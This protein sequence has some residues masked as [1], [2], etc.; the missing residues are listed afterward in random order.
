[1]RTYA[2][3]AAVALLPVGGLLLA[4][5]T[6]TP[7]LAQGAPSASA[8]VVAV[9]VVTVPLASG[10]ASVDVPVDG[11]IVAL[12][13][14]DLGFRIPGRLARVAVKFGERVKRGQVLAELEAN[15][16]ALSAKI[17]VAQAAQARAG[18]EAAEDT[19]GR[20]KQLA[21]EGFGAE[22]TTAGST[23]ALAQSRAAF[24]AAIA[25]AA[26]SRVQVGEHRLLAP[27]DGVVA[28]PPLAV[29]ALVMQTTVLHLIDD[30][31][32]RFRGALAERHALSLAPGAKLPV[33]LVDGTEIEGVVEVLGLR[34]DAI[35]GNVP[36]EV[37]LPTSLPP[38]VRVGA[39]ARGRVAAPVAV[40]RAPVAALRTLGGRDVVL[41]PR[42]EIAVAV[43]V[44]VVARSA[45]EVSFLADLPANA[46]VVVAP[47]ELPEGS[48]IER[49]AEGA[50]P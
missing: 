36:L 20:A 45:Q 30:R 10:F 39:S 35:T 40:R 46:A 11:A 43:P 41:V 22:A 3:L 18:L 38:S 47:A 26:L 16:A 37:S 48:R 24:D 5:R 49:K 29:G 27:F 1:M 50:T 44:E 34:L 25:T 33:R 42:D 28:T 13:A 15:D 21:A 31:S 12:R 9:R 4:S 23:H 8:S 17:A 32:L 19:L 2:L 6:S 14:A 7:A